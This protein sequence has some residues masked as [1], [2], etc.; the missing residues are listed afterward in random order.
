MNSEKPKCGDC[1]YACWTWDEKWNFHCLRDGVCVFKKK[2]TWMSGIEFEGEKLIVQQSNYY[3]ISKG[4]VVCLTVYR[5]RDVFR[6]DDQ[7]LSVPDCPRFLDKAEVIGLL[8]ARM[9]K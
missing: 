9:V 5:D 7:L 6:M 1:I 3:H 8:K 4:E 2:E